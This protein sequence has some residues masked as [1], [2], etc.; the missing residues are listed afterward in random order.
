MSAVLVAAVPAE[1]NLPLTL[2]NCASEPIHTPGHT[3]PHGTL[4]AF[5]QQGVLT[6][7]FGIEHTPAVLSQKGE[8]LDIREVV[9]PHSGATP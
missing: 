6:S 2:D 3:Q 1:N 7:R 8:A 4:F 5:D 9:L